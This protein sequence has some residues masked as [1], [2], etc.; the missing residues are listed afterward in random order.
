MHAYFSLIHQ[1]IIITPILRIVKNIHLHIYLELKRV[2][3]C[4]TDE[5]LKDSL[6]NLPSIYIYFP[7][8][9]Y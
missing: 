6:K 4:I 9:F 8:S 5:L 1:N 2:L 3:K 7:V